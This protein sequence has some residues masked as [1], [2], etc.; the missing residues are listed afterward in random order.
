MTAARPQADPEAA[1]AHP[2]PPA[3]SRGYIRLVEQN[4]TVCMICAQEC[5]TW[6]IEIEGHVEKTA[7]ADPPAGRRIPTSNVLDR[8]AIDYSLCMYCGICVE[9]CPFDALAWTP[10]YDYAEGE[11]SA[12]THERGELSGS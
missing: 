9:A 10:H 5:P 4:C 11:R 3:G 6:C 2:G 12:L 7:P 1:E 8:F